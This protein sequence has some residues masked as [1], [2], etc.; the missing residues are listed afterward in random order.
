MP[1]PK[2]RTGQKKLSEV[3]RHV[4]QPAG[5]VSTGWPAV[6]DRCKSFGILFDRWQ[7]GLG[8]LALSKRADGLYA[9]AIGGVNVS[10]PRQTGK[11]YTFGWLVF[12]L[13]TLYADVTVVWTAHRTRTSDETFEKMKA[14]AM[15]PKVAG[16]VDGRPR[17]ANGQQQIRFKNGSRI[18]FGAREQGFGRGFDKIDV[19]VFDEAQILTESALSDMVP[20]TNAAPNG[21]VLMMGTPPRPRDPGEAFANR[22][23]DGIA[24]DP[25]TVYVEFSASRD[26]KIIDWDELAVANPSFPHRTSKTAVLRMQKLLGSDENF[27]REA[28]GIWDDT[29]KGAKAIKFPHWRRLTV[30]PSDAPREGRTAYAVR[31]SVDGQTA[32]LAVARRPANGPIHVEGVAVYDM[33]EGIGPIVDFLVERSRTATHIAI[34]GKAGA[35][36]LI[37]ALRDAGVKN[38]RLIVKMT[39]DLVTSSCAELLQALT[40]MSLSHIGQPLLNRQVEIA[41]PRKIGN[42]G[43]FGWGAPDGEDV[44]LLEAA[45]YAF[46]MVKNTKRRVGMTELVGGG[47]V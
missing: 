3:A 13:C 16:Y 18:L 47:L 14:M 33:A 26:A 39:P 45:T 43:G 19:L 34:D 23:D 12:A 9:A 31:F 8:R 44:S 36:L 7:D 30:D 20:A 6:R 40:D 1:S 41:A 25:D 24:G 5:I 15:R 27:M 11:T 10:I 46:A 35:D 42:Y 4:C 21:L 37:Q 29:S 38:K 2:M 28:Y 22:R 32:G 17:S